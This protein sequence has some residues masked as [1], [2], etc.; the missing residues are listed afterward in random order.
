MGI[1]GTIQVSYEGGDFQALL[2]R[3]VRYRVL[4]FG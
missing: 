2:H 4:Y 1:I 3:H